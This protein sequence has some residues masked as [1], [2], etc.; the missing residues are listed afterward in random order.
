M[1][2]HGPGRGRWRW[3]VG[4]AG[5]AGR[6][7]SAAGSPG[8]QVFLQY[9]EQEWDDMERRMPDVFL[10]GY[11]AFW[12]PPPHLASF[13]SPGYDPFDRFSL[14]TPPLLTNSTSRTR[15]TYG[16]EA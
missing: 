7:G 13:A 10:A 3:G 16:T 6:G 14:G 15:T 5:L 8:N 2:G 1:P 12:L 9:F 4:A 11:D